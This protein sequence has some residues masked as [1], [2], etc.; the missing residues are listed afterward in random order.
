MVMLILIKILFVVYLAAINF[1]GFILVSQHKRAEEDGDACS[2]K[3]GKVFVSGMLGGALGV[4]VAMFVFKYRLTSLAL[5][6]LMPIFIAL[7]VYAVIMLF[8]QNFGIVE[9]V[10][11]NLEGMLGYVEVFFL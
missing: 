4:F 2:V 3:D 8:T 9:G 1:Y 6:V 10:G 11:N 7:S 5:M